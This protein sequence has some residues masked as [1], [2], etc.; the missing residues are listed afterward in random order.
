MF[1]NYIEMKDK[2]PLPLSG[3]LYHVT[4]NGIVIDINDQEIPSYLNQSNK[5]VVQLQWIDGYKEYEIERL[6]LHTF[7][8]LH[9]PFRYWSLLSILYLDGNENNLMLENLIWKFPIEGIECRQYP[10]YYYIPCFTRYVINK[11]GDVIKVLDGR[12]ISILTQP[13]GYKSYTMIN[14]LNIRRCLQRHRALAITF[15]DYPVNVDDLDTNHID[16]IPGNDWVENLEL[17]THKENLKHAVK[18]GLHSKKPKP[19]LMRNIITGEITEF[20]SQSHC[21]RFLDINLVSLQG[22]LYNPKQQVYSGGFQFKYKDD[23]TPWREVEDVEREL[24]S[25]GS[26][27]KIL[28]RN[29]KTNEIIEYNSGKDC[30]NSLGIL[31]STLVWRL[32]DTKQKVYPG[33]FQFKYKDDPTPWREVE[34][35]DIENETFWNKKPVLVRNVLTGEIR[36]FSG[37]NDC[38]RKLKLNRGSVHRRLK[39]EGQPVFEDM[40]QF[41]FKHDNSQWR[42]PVPEELINGTNTRSKR[43][44]VTNLATNQVTEYKSMTECKRALSI[45]EI[46]LNH[47]LKGNKYPNGINGYKAVFK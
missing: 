27:R 12:N 22:R 38:I 20:E 39:L 19:V 9:L 24:D 32:Q 26:N 2:L 17:I 13:K 7:K 31:T 1:T 4:I 3:D 25:I 6:L 44:I 43:I 45:G 14:D 40:T 46:N 42:E 11:Q 10:S 37:I 35:S 8:P 30:A 34:N 28:V 36:E 16:G 29:V 47:L 33:G 21:S 23:P 5:L 41:K 15:L 18:I